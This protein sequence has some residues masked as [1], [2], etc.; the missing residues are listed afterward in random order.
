MTGTTPVGTFNQ[1]N[2][3]S[4]GGQTPTVYFGDVDANWAVVTRV[5]DLFA[6][7]A[8]VTPAMSVVIDPGFVKAIRATGLAVMTE[9]AAQTVTI[10]TAP[11]APNNR[12]DLLV[13]D[14]GTGAAS[15]IA[16][17]PSTTPAAPALT[18]GKL[19]VAAVAV[20]NGVTTILNANITDLRDVWGAGA[21]NIPWAVGSG[22]GNA[23]TAAYTPANPA[24]YDGLV[25]AVR[26]P[27]A[28]TATPVTFAP[29]GL[30]AEP[31]TKN[32]GMG[33][34]VGDIPSAAA[35]M[36][37][38]YNLAG[39]CWEWTNPRQAIY[40]LTAPEIET[41]LGYTPASAGGG[42]SLTASEIETALGFTPA[43]TYNVG[44][45]AEVSAI[46]GNTTLTSANFGEVIICNGSSTSYTVTLPSPLIAAVLEFV[47]NTGATVFLSGSFTSS[48]GTETSLQLASGYGGYCRIVG[49]GST[50]QVLQ[51]FENTMTFSSTGGG[52]TDG[53]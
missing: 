35:E 43:A 4:S 41:A 50:W 11:S 53:G 13:V 48:L 40:T 24:L 36:M 5:G 39:T 15:I 3:A 20:G 8:A 46:G 1:T 25:L 28:N 33:L 37:L 26:A 32:G 18:A 22:T 19:K 49:T 31:I 52:G 51:Y 7:H 9:V 16:G 6:P 2:S 47:C 21:P 17:S 30:P 44:N 34:S 12:I 29:D 45:V 42:S 23:I 38:R 10:A 27:G 14:A